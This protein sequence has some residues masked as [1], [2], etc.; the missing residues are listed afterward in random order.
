MQCAKEHEETQSL[1]ETMSAGNL[2]ELLQ[3]V[4][5]F[6]HQFA[7]HLIGI[8]GRRLPEE[9]CQ[10]VI[11][12]TLTT[13]LE[14]DE[15]GSLVDHHHITCLTIAIEEALHIAC[16]R[17]VLGQQTEIGFQ[18]Q[19][20]EIYL[21][22]FQEAIL[23]V[24]EVEEHGIG[25]KSRLRI[26]IAEVE[27]S[28]TTNLEFWQLTD[29]ASQEFL[30]MQSIAATGFTTATNGIEQRLTAEVGLNVA[31]LVAADCQHLWHG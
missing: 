17:Q 28:C 31:Q 8:F 1:D 13:T 7:A 15:I 2:D 14:V 25:I 29:G 20:M 26:A 24:V 6:K 12:R 5:V 18:F 19:L 9:R 22:S 3:C 10:V 11:V 30:L 27:T 4:V 23:E 16:F 21:G